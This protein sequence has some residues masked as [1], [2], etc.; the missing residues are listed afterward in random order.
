MG[1][2]EAK[3]FRELYDGLKVFIGEHDGLVW[4]AVDLNEI[5]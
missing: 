1:K 3:K 4:I 5:D 2:Y